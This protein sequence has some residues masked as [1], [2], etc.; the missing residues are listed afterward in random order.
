MSANAVTGNHQPYPPQELG[1]Y[2]RCMAD[3]CWGLKQR[4]H[5]V[6]VICNDAI[7][8]GDSS[9]HGPSAEPIA[10]QLLLKGDFC[11]GVH[12]MQSEVEK[13]AVDKNNLE[14]ILHWL[15]NEH[16]DGILIGNLD[17]LGVELLHWLLG[18]GLPVLHHIGF[19][20]SPYPVNKQPQ[21]DNYHLLAASHAVKT[22]LVQEGIRA[23]EASVVYPGARTEM[24]GPEA[25][26][27]ALPKPPNRNTDSHCTSAL[28]ITD[29]KQGATYTP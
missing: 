3:F 15:R 4:G 1:G 11:N 2:G 13:N 8:L 28:Q 25:I 23:K 14:V 29:G 21:V 27:R 7:Y 19:V 12:L 9:E 24:F 10:R 18:H 17:L 26:S 16:W 5:H 22:R 20:Q 6:Q